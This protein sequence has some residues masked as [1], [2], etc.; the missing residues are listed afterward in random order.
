MLPYGC[1]KLLNFK[2]QMY[3]ANINEVSILPILHTVFRPTHNT[4]ANLLLQPAAFLQKP[5]KFPGNVQFKNKK[6]IQI[7]SSCLSEFVELTVT[8]QSLLDKS[9]KMILV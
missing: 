1:L 5:Q 9:L 8:V 3:I 4:C 7:L 2:L 6:M